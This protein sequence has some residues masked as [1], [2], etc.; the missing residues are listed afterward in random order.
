M[1]ATITQRIDRLDWERIRESIDERGYATTPA[2]LTPHECAELAALYE[3]RERFRSRIDMTR[4][5]FGVG[6]YKYFAH[7]LPAV[8]AAM[9][10]AVYPPLAPLAS[11]WVRAMRMGP[12]FPPDLESFLEICHRSGQTRPTPLILRYDAGG[13]NCM[14]QDIY[15]EV[16]FPIQLTCVLSRREFDFSGGEFM[17]LEQRPRAQ[18][19]CEAITLDQGEAILFATRYRPVKGARGYY[20]ANLRHGVSSIHSGRRFSLGVI[21]HDAK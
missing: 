21:F 2:L 3:E 18:S 14:H 5:R 17:L 4:F 7:P 10:M 20:R 12:D 19:R 8:V 16:V 13:Y 11:Q 1:G 15:G 6:E 9:R